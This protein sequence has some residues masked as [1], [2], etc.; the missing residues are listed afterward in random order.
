MD[1]NVVL[2]YSRELNILY[3]E[4]DIELQRQTT[5]IF[6][7]FFKTVDTAENGEI[8]LEKYKK[9][10]QDHDEYYDLIITDI[11]MP[12][13]N[14]IDFSEDVLKINSE[15]KIIV[16]S[17]H[18]EVQYLNDL[19]NIG[20]TG[21]L[22]KPI[23]MSTLLGC[24]YRTTQAISDRK[25]VKAFYEEIERLNDELTHKNS[26][27]EKS[28]RILKTNHNKS[29]IHAASSEKN[30]NTI[31]EKPKQSEQERSELL[32]ALKYELPELSDICMELDV[33]IIDIVT[34]AN[35]EKLSEITA[36]FS[37]FANSLSAFHLFAPLQSAIMSLVK[38]LNELKLPKEN[39]N[40][41]NGV[42]LLE[43]LIYSLNVWVGEWDE[44]RSENISFYDASIISDI[45][46]II[47]FWTTEDQSDDEDDNDIELF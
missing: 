14:G 4:D 28:L 10:F 43:S 40:I 45:N 9:Y 37:K 33:T 19:I 16:I 35:Y 20:V 32:D 15:Q 6:K 24:L 2:E 26:E 22:L 7:E 5:D 29:S 34:H 12:V 31:Q 21:F 39:K 25:T 17:A 8:A 18:N 36:L 27:L 47:K 42:L 46:S 1:I 38:T 13:K 3:V 41:K 30:P 23:S 44:Q 11:N